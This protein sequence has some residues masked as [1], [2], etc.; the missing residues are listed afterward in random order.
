MWPR[1]YNLAA[2]IYWTCV[3]LAPCYLCGLKIET[4]EG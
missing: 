2:F 3:D 1:K 4:D